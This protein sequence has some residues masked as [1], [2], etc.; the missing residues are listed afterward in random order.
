MTRAELQAG[1]LNALRQVAPEVDAAALRPDQNLRDQVDLDSV[2][3]LNFIIEL[4]RTLGVEVPETD[5]DALRTLDS[6]VA[7]LERRTIAA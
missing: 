1:V 5:Y 3:F 4:H 2:D 6:T 7:Y